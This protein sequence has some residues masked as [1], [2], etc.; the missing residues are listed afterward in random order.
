VDEEVGVHDLDLFIGE[1]G[2]GGGGDEEE[3]DR[4]N[5]DGQNSCAHRPNR[6]SGWLKVALVRAGVKGEIAG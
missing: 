1:L 6:E 3:N 5:A 4:E 2:A